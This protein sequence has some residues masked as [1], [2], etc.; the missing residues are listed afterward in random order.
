LLSREDS[1]RGETAGETVLAGL[2]EFLPKGEGQAL[3]EG[4]LPRKETE[5]AGITG[6]G[7]ELDLLKKI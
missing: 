7:W 5:I 2:V 3:C 6:H 1:G 4:I